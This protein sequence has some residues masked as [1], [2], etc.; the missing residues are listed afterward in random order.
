MVRKSERVRARGDEPVENGDAPPPALAAPADWQAMLDAME[1]RLLRV[2]EA[3]R[4]YRRQAERQILEAV[5]PPV[6][7]PAPVL[8]VVVG[9]R[10]PLFKRFRKQHPPTFEGSTDPLVAE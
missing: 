6:Q 4:R 3:A 9:N 7:P 8:P 5:V 10:E 1:A 2:E